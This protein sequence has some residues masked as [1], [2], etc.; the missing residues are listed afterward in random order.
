MLIR[1]Y[2]EE[3]K[4]IMWQKIKRRRKKIMWQKIFIILIPMMFQK[5]LLTIYAVY[6]FKLKIMFDGILT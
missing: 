5:E 4:I 3:E 2:K 6:I 1:T